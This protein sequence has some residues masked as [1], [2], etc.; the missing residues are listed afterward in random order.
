MQPYQTTLDEQAGNKY[1]WSKNH[2]SY[3]IAYATRKVFDAE[4][5]KDLVQDTFLAALE[6]THKFEGR[7]SERTWLVSILTNKIIDNYRKKE[8]M[9]AKLS[10]M[11][12]SN[13]VENSFTPPED[14]LP[15]LQNAVVKLPS[16]WQMVFKM[17]HLEEQ[18]AKIIC[19]ELN[20]TNANYWVINHRTKM[21]LQTRLREFQFI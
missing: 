4:L 14:F 16:L 1:F 13:M 19:K 18:P 5:A 21:S 17:K 8:M 3:L 15:K 11:A 10:R 20:I 6:S 7:S 12:V 2:S 9:A